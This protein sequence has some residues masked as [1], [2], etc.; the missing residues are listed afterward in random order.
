MTIK[1]A[2]IEMSFILS[3]Q[4]LSV[5][6]LG[7]NICGG[8]MSRG[9]RVLH[10]SAVDFLTWTVMREDVSGLFICLSFSN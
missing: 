9:V 7:V 5:L 1:D 6:G 4:G 2:N 3:L 8:G 10:S